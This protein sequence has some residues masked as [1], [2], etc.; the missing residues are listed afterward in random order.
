MLEHFPF[1][2]ITSERILTNLFPK[3]QRKF[4]PEKELVPIFACDFPVPKKCD[5][6][7]KGTGF[8][9]VT[10]KRFDLIVYIYPIYEVSFHHVEAIQLVCLVS[11]R[12]D[13]HHKWVKFFIMNR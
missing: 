13:I 3:S 10:A 7:P 5:E 2:M 12:W 4:L 8:F 11:M 9:S 1:L 6:D